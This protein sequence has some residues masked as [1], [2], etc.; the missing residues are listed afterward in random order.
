M[1]KLRLVYFISYPLGC[2]YFALIML[3][4]MQLNQLWCHRKIDLG[5]NGPAGPI[6]DEKWSGQTIFG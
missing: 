3:I 5:K 6:L 2:V 4:F 1:L